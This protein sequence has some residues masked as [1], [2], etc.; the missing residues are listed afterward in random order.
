L[1]YTIAFVITTLFIG[2]FS[3]IIILES[4]P[5]PEYS[6]EQMIRKPFT[7]EEKLLLPALGEEASRSRTKLSYS[8]LRPHAEFEHSSGVMV[9]WPLGIPIEL[10]RE[11]ST[12]DRVITIVTSALRPTAE[13]A[14]RNAGVNMDNVEFLITQSNSYWTRDY[15]P[16]FAYDTSGELLAIDFTYNRPQRPLDNLI[17]AVFAPFDDLS[18]LH[19]GILHEGGNYMADGI[20]IAASTDL[21]Y[22]S[23]NLAGINVDSVRE[24]LKDYLGV[25][26]HLTIRCPLLPMYIEHID[27]WAKFLAPDKI[28]IASVPPDHVNHQDLEDA[29]EFFG[30][31]KT[32]WGRPFEVIRVE[33][34]NNQP[35]T[36]SLILN[37]RVFVPIGPWR[38]S[39]IMNG[40]TPE[41]DMAA[42]QV[43]SE[44]MPGYTIIGV[45]NN[46]GTPWL[47][48]DGL[49]CRVKEIAER[50]IIN[51]SHTP[52]PRSM[53]LSSEIKISAEIR[54]FSWQTIN[55]DSVNLFYSINGSEF[56]KKAMTL[57]YERNDLFTAIISRLSPRDSVAYYIRAMNEMEMFF[58]HPFIGA[59]M[60]HWTVLS[61]A[62]ESITITETVP[63]MPLQVSV[64][65]N[66]LNTIEEKVLKVSVDNSTSEKVS[67][68]LF[69][70]RG[71][72]ITNAEFPITKHGMNV[73]T[74]DLSSFDLAS[75]IYFMRIEDMGHSLIRRVIM[76]R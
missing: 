16:L 22:T 25:T 30:N 37:N 6:A 9:R 5:H 23:N 4:V 59:S 61:D 53:E 46:T 76:V 10:I 44:A 2:L 21:V 66:P 18:L 54:S 64:F 62:E 67:L 75:G 55:A 12:L 11:I 45:P 1:R 49:H 50:D 41:V 70:V 69:N 7:E 40:S 71:Q 32:A 19:M 48:S 26:E 52:L 8:I 63:V 56:S 36:N 29:S 35:F 39:S 47:S 27:C 73:I 33:A 28:M 42:L 57:C 72:R 3:N 38:H 74:W 31:F 51:I 65:P 14:F 24:A 60:A 34:P 20:H 17:N 15:G 43:Y 58:Y 13:N 68:T